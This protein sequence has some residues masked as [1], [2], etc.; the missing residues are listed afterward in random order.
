MGHVGV[1]HAAKA[2]VRQARDFRI[3]PLRGRK[4]DAEI[5]P[6]PRL[7]RIRHHAGVEAVDAR[8]HDH[9]ALDPERVMQREQ[10]ALGRIAGL[11]VA[12]GCE[13]ELSRR[14][15]H[16]AVR[17]GGAFGQNEGQLGSLRSSGAC[18]SHRM[19]PS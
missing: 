14:A 3:R 12:F 16:M 5:L 6:R 7:D 8:S 11:K 1:A 2:L 17:V 13:R 18:A 10:S 15:E 4:S 9:A 19:P